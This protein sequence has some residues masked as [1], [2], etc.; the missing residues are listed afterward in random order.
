MGRPTL[1][2]ITPEVLSW[3]IEESGYSMGQIA[4]DLG[5]PVQQLSSWAHGRGRPTLTQFRKL[6]AV[7]RRTPATLLLPQPPQLPKPLVQLRRPPRADRAALLPVELQAIREATS[8]QRLLSWTAHEMRAAPP[9]LPLVHLST[10]A[11]Q[12]AAQARLRL[13]VDDEVQWG[14]ASPSQALRAWRTALE[15]TGVVVFLLPLGEDA[16]RGFSIWDD[17][18]P[19]VAANTSWNAAARIYTL[20]HE[21]GHLLTRTD[22]ACLEVGTWSALDPAER[23]CERFSA[24]FLMPWASMLRALRELGWEPGR[25]IS[26]IRIA[27]RLANRFK[28][29]VR[30]ATLRLMEKGVAAADLYGR[31]P[32]LTDRKRR[33]GAAGSGR[34]RRQIREDEYGARTIALLHSAVQ[35]DIIDRAEVLSYLNIPA[36]DFE[37]PK[38]SVL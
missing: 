7:L 29:S 31:I 24:A 20:F 1:V 30:A 37:P 27:Q 26:E 25:R 32:P 33:G 22:S 15:R 4:D 38:I 18:A 17:H 19:L 6:A 13:G 5:V 36:A 28:V 23:W 14:W 16:C 21:Y 9:K 35:H 34:T 12:A 8:L 10:D 11:E 3:A 2:T